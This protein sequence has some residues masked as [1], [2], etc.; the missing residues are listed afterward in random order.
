MP[1]LPKRG[2]P[3][4]PRLLLRFGANS[5]SKDQTST[6]TTETHEWQAGK[7][8]NSLWQAGKNGRYK[9]ARV[10]HSA[11]ALSKGQSL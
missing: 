4:A 3:P 9:K 5:S 1:P 11:R 6:T 7:R 10:R 8:T 2:A